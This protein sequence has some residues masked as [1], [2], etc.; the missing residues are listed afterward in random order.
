MWDGKGTSNL[1]D[2]LQPA[3]FEVRE[4][5]APYGQAARP[6]LLDKVSGELRL[7]HYSRR[8]EEAYRHWIVRFL[9][10]HGCR[11]PRE[12]GGPEVS[13]FLTHLAAGTRRRSHPEPGSRRAVVPLPARLGCRVALA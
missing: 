6:R 11:H 1:L 7:R 8:T 4:D 5:A 10:F 12:L 2:L 9:R 3:G 13:A